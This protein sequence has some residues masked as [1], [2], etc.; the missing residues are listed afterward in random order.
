MKGTRENL[1]MGVVNVTPDSFSDG[2]ECLAPSAAVSRVR[3]MF[4]QGAD[5]VDIGGESSR[6]GAPQ[7]SAEEELGRLRPV[8]SQL[9]KELRSKI[10]VDT[11]KPEVME[12]MAALGA[13]YIN[14]IR[15]GCD[16]AVLSRLATMGVTYIAMH[17]HLEPMNMQ[18]DPLSA[19]AAVS[20]VRVFFSRAYERLEALG[21]SPSQIWLD[22]G[23]GFGKTDA[24]NLQ[25]MKLSLELAEDYS[26]VMGVSRKSFL[27]RTLSIS[28]PKDRDAATKA[29]ELGMMLSG[30]KAFRTHDVGTLVQLRELLNA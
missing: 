14:D 12:E 21:F 13:G 25:L 3:Q 16:D 6:P 26:I 11:Y 27:G 30:V 22:P 28:H 2:G 23:I 18:Q 4:D 19:E 1:V 15:G 9:P 10:S 24:A 20:E 29:L 8:L 7:V 17:M 5:L